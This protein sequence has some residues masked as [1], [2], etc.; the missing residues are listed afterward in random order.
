VGDPKVQP[1]A[2]KHVRAYAGLAA[3]IFVGVAESTEVSSER[4]LRVNLLGSQP[5]RLGRFQEL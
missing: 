1:S 3:V 5:D 4:G 2:Q